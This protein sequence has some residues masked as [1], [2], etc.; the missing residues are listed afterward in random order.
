MWTFIS[1]SSLQTKDANQC[2]LNPIVHPPTGSETANRCSQI[3]PLLH[4][5]FP[6]EA[7]G[8]S[9]K[10]LQPLMPPAMIRGL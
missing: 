5:K 10:H 7:R 6:R 1:T 2:F 4:L 8:V 9:P 3:S